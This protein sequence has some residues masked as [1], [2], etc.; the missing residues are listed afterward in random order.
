MPE[1]T[2]L[3]CW[4]HQSR[5]PGRSKAARSE[6]ACCPN[7]QFGGTSYTSPK[8]NPAFFSKMG[9]RITRPSD[10]R[11]FQDLGDT[12][13]RRALPPRIVSSRDCGISPAVELAFTDWNLY[14]EAHCQEHQPSSSED[15][16]N[17][18]FP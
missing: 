2:D 5:G 16:P 8:T 18:G 1:C 12:P 10:E 13:E 3:S 7:L 14:P 6:R 11:G 17:R 9:T 15:Q 4:R